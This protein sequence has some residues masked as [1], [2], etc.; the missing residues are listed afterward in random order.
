[1]TAAGW[2]SGSGTAC[3]T[4]DAEHTV[5]GRPGGPLHGHDEIAAYYDALL[6]A[7]PITRQLSS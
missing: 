2:L 3:F 5:A 6:T 4:Q 1:M 7:L